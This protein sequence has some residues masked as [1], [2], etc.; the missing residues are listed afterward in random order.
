M[1]INTANKTIWVSPEMGLENVKNQVRYKKEMTISK[2]KPTKINEDELV[3]PV[4]FISVTKITNLIRTHTIKMKTGTNS[5]V[6]LRP[7]RTPIH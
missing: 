7:Y 3:V 2:D 4:D 5:T 6:K 1:I